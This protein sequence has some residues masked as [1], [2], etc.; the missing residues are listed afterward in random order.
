MFVQDKQIIKL[1][2]KHIDLK[3]ERLSV[4]LGAGVGSI[5]IELWLFFIGLSLLRIWQ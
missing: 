5:R 3:V 1:Y 4:I 2:E